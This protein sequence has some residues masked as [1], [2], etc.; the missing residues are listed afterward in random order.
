VDDALAVVRATRDDVAEG[1]RLLEL[2]PAGVR[3]FIR[4][5]GYRRGE[6]THE[7]VA[8][9]HVLLM[10]SPPARTDRAAWLDDELHEP[11]Q[12]GER[13]LRRGAGRRGG[14]G[15]SGGRGGSRARAVM[16]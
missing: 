1:E 8:E 12:K 2:T 10:S 13:T 9:I 7:L 11:P 15:G 5:A 16:T 14:P 3:E 6:Y 4:R